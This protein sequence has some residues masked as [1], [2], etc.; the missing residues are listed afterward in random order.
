MQKSKGLFVAFEGLDGSGNSTQAMLLE[1]YLRKAGRKTI[2][3][4]EPTTGIIGGIIKSSLAGELK[5]SSEATQLLFAS[6]RAQHLKTQIIPALKNGVI[7]ITDRYLFS[8]LAYG[9]ASGLDPKW[10]YEINRRF[11]MPDL[12]F[13]IDVSP[14]T[15]IKRISAG[16][17]NFELFEKEN[18]LSK[19]RKEYKKL[20]KEYNFEKINGEGSIEAVHKKVINV[21]RKYI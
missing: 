3:T 9:T 21:I 15:S 7:I 2:L 16:R 11:L 6:D 17:F 8:S 10:L 5:I 13:F 19:V 20:A 1:T 18:S 12:T 14:E 4:K